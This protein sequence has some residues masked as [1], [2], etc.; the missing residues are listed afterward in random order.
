MSGSV[1][2]GGNTTMNKTDKRP[3]ALRELAF[4]WGAGMGEMRINTV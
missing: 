3:P 4:W 2:G 1:P